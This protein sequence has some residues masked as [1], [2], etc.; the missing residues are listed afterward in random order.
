[1]A[2]FTSITFVTASVPATSSLNHNEILA[3][4]P[5]SVNI[6]RIKIVPS[7]VG[8]TTEAQIYEKD[9]F[10][11]A[12]LV[13]GTNPFAAT[14]FDPIQKDAAGVI[15]EANR[16]FIVPYED[17]D[18]SGE[19][20]IKL[21]NNDSSA[22]TYTITIDYEAQV[23]A[24]GSF[25]TGSVLFGGVIGDIAQDNSNFFWDD[26]ANRLGLGTLSPTHTLDVRGT[27]LVVRPAA[28]QVLSFVVR[29]AAATALLGVS[30]DASNPRL[31]LSSGTDFEMF[32]DTFTTSKFRVDGPT[33]DTDIA[34]R[35][36]TGNT[37]FLD[38][39]AVR[40][41]GNFTSL[42]ASDRAHKLLLDGILTG[43]AGDI[44]S[45]AGAKFTN[46]I[47]T[48]TATEG[49]VTIAQVWIDEPQ[50]TDNLTGTI[51]NS[52]SLFISQAANEATNN[53]ALWVQ[54]GNVKFD[55]QLVVGQGILDYVRV[56][57][58]GS[59]TS[60]GASNFAAGVFI[61]TTLTGFSGDTLNLSQ[62]QIGGTI[63]TQVT[64]TVGLVA[65]LLL[66]EP[67][68]TV[69][70][71]GAVTTATTMY[72]QNAPD[73]GTNNYALLVDSG[74]IRFDEELEFREMTSPIAGPTNSARVFAED[75]GSGKT[76]LMVRFP[77]GATQQ[78]AIE[79]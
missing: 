5:D 37:A 12:N 14:G 62:L 52:A 6:Y 17:L 43:A 9:T 18:A 33:G 30:S 40:L 76:R 61:N 4:T 56:R 59:F 73:E 77:T 49:I 11:T 36:I 20:H 38:Y 53:Y 29:D 72:I 39:V 10:L 54:A 58:G 24:I 65:A 13:W 44:D 27:G 68:I 7:I 25:T 8:G 3:G 21:I 50:I 1:M 60:G 19:L 28:D 32:S 71:G 45:L 2:R 67:Q 70:G 63:T 15:T 26:V 78:L 34:G 47:V 64:D 42:G 51:T 41:G 22:K 69:G 48:Q 79:P 55:G 46:S 66:V 35:L 31:E 23:T 57:I 75:N 74:A 16:G